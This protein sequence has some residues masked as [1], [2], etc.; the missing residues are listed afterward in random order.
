MTI[1]LPCVYAN[2][3]G[4]QTDLALLQVY[5]GRASVHLPQPQPQAILAS[6]GTDIAPALHTS[7]SFPG[8]EEIRSRF[9]STQLLATFLS[10]LTLHCLSQFL[11]KEP[12]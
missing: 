7:F 11:Q 9:L 2:L 5:V 4:V 12:D 6:D 1:F 8:R 3:S 10:N